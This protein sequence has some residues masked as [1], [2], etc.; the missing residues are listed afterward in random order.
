MGIKQKRAPNANNDKMATP[1][2]EVAKCW[3]R[4]TGRRIGRGTEGQRDREWDGQGPKVEKQVAPFGTF[5]APRLVY[6][7]WPDQNEVGAAALPY[8]CFA[9]LVFNFICAHSTWNTLCIRAAIPSDLTK[10]ETKTK[11]NRGCKI[12][13]HGSSR[14]GPRPGPVTNSVSVD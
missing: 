3:Q 2:A 11:A 13:S 9:R 6:P 10:T 7:L 8:F 1:A 4:Q 5:A 14:P 12:V